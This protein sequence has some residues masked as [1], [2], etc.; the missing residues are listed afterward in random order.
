MNSPVRKPDLTLFSV[1][2]NSGE[3]YLGKC[4][5]RDGE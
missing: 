2:F 4:V 1:L 5:R 3:A